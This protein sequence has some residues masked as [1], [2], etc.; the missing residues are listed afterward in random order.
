MTA[1]KKVNF[2]SCSQTKSLGIAEHFCMDG[3]NFLRCKSVTKITQM[4]ATTVL[5]SLLLHK[6]LDFN[7]I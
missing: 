7:Y 1:E 2:E 4:K 6:Y 5:E 3:L